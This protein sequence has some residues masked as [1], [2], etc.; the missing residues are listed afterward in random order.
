MVPRSIRILAGLLARDVTIA[1]LLCRAMIPQQTAREGSAP[2]QDAPAASQ[3]REA[4]QTKVIVYIKGGQGGFQHP[5]FYVSK[6]PIAGPNSSVSAIAK[7]QAGR[8]VVLTL[9]SRPTRFCVKKRTQPFCTVVDLTPSRTTYIRASN[10]FAVHRSDWILNV[11]G[12]QDGFQDMHRVFM[13]PLQ[14]IDPK[15]VIDSELV[16]R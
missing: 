7:L 14:P 4:T 10:R 2:P 15:M 6:K 9:P 13:P 12:E 8:Y 16:R 11:M 3:N 1:L 5:I